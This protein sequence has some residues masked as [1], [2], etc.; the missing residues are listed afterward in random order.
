MMVRPS[1]GFEK[2]QVGVHRTVTNKK[3]E[4][5]KE[6]SP[7]VEYSNGF[8]STKCKAFADRR[9]ADV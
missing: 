6:R 2:I 9:I 4:A 1:P 3:R 7:R 5:T 8:E